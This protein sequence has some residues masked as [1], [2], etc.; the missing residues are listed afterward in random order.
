MLELEFGSDIS[1]DELVWSSVMFSLYGYDSHQ[2]NIS[3]EF[4]IKR[5]FILM[6]MSTKMI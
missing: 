5:Q 4:W 2:E 3:Y 6:S 1:S